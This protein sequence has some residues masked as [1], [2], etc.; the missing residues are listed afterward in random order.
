MWA[1]I[2]Y[3]MGLTCRDTK[4]EAVLKQLTGPVTTCLNFC[5]PDVSACREGKGD[6]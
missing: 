1:E 3:E 4:W 5:N 2:S 6:G